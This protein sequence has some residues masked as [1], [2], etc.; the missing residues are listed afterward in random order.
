MIPPVTTN[1]LFRITSNQNV[2]ICR[3]VNIKY[4]FLKVS[5]SWAKSILLY[6]M[7]NYK[8]VNPVTF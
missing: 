2:D 4:Y 1:I 6:V 5:W 8:I 3:N 7:L